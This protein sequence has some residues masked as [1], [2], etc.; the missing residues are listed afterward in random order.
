MTTSI[1]TRPDDTPRVERLRIGDMTV[2]RPRGGLDRDLAD[3][4]RQFAL[5]AHGPVVIDLDECILVDP[6]SV[7]R[8]AFEWEMY[9][10]EMCVVSS[11][12]ATRELRHHVRVDEEL[13]VFDDVD[14]ALED[15]RAS[16]RWSTS[17]E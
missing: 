11:R 3:D 12:N 13:L 14:R 6:R 9:R 2:L 5:E 7:Q 1:G 4:V 16:G 8:L 17:I 10:P 15:R